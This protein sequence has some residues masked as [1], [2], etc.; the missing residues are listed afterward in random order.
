MQVGIAVLLE[1]MG[2]ILVLGWLWVRHRQRPRPFTIGGAVAA[3]AGLAMMAGITGSSGISGIGLMWGLLNAGS[4]AVYFLL[5]SG[6]A[7]P[8]ATAETGEPLSPVVLSWA[9]LCVGT[10]V[11]VVLGLARAL[12]LAASTRDVTFLGRQTS[13]VMPVIE[14]GVVATAAGYTTGITAIRHLG[15]KLASFIGMSEV[16]FAALL[17]WAVFGQV[18]SGTEIGGGVLILAGVAL[19]R[20]DE[21]GLSHGPSLARRRRSRS[22]PSRRS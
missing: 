21:A 1:F 4:V 12:P 18:P 9:S 11:I 5:A 14:I 3:I 13:W 17:A 19:V 15:P 22:R 7:S 10:M 6:R 8:G 20:A 2:A 16:L